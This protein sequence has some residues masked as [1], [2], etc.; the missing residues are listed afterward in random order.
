MFIFTWTEVDFGK[1]KQW[2]PPESATFLSIELDGTCWMAIQ[3][4]KS[5]GFGRKYVPSNW[6]NHGEAFPNL[7]EL[8][9]PC[10]LMHFAIL[11]LAIK[12]KMSWHLEMYLH[13]VVPYVGL[14]ESTSS[15][16]HQKPSKS[17]RL[18]PPQK[19]IMQ[20]V[21][22]LESNVTPMKIAIKKTPNKQTNKQTKQNKTKHPSRWSMVTGQPPPPTTAHL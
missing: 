10:H 5:I 21:N 17:L 18:L 16:Y 20:F 14:P 4:K 6:E 8:R 15:A 11:S 1:M 7:H 2:T 19:K 22:L 12:N 9:H 3:S 13:M